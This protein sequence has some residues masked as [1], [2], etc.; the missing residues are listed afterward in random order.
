MQH[1]PTWQ[2][3]HRVQCSRASPCTVVWPEMAFRHWLITCFSVYKR[4]RTHTATHTHVSLKQTSHV[5]LCYCVSVPSDL[6][7]GMTKSGTEDAV[8]MLASLAGD[9]FPATHSLLL[10]SSVACSGVLKAQS[11]EHHIQYLCIVAGEV[12]I[13]TLMHV[14][15]SPQE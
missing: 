11:S 6:N 10:T 5:G 8:C 2:S 9:T 13:L 1:L 12:R 4:R 7:F 14:P 3:L 15:R